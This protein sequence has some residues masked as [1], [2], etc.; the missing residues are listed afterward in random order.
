MLRPG[1]IGVSGEVAAGSPPIL[2]IA[3]ISEPAAF[4]RTA[5]IEALVRAGIKVAAAQVGA[6]AALPD[7]GSYAD[8][9]K[10][11]EHVSPPLSEYTKVILKISY[12]R[13]ADL[14]VCLAA[15][16]S[17]SRN[18]ADGLTQILKLLGRHGLAE[19]GTYVFD[20]A[21]SD[22]GGKTTPADLATFL[23]EI[24]A[25]PWGPSLRDGMAVLGVDG[26]QAPN[27]AGTPAAGHVRVKDGARS[28]EAPPVRASR[29]PIPRPAI[30]TPKAG[31]GSSMA[32]SSTTRRSRRSKGSL[33]T[34]QTW[35][36]S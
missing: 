14:M 7:R 32:C 12:N 30:S 23:R 19:S 29:S 24:I 9:D 5:F 36:P 35:R 6:P 11:A 17:G 2:S 16:K 33:P 20:G 3:P 18:C 27:G 28:S 13:G 4:A 8:A 34:G 1:V 22:D 21:G 25:E 31:A 26:T 15:V 10:V